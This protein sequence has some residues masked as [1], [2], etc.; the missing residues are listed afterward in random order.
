MTLSSR[1]VDVLLV[2]DLRFPGGTSHSMATE[3]RALHRQISRIAGRVTEL[4]QR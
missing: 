4:E 2:S 1:D 3:V